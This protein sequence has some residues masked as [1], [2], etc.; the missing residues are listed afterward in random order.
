MLVLG[1][2]GSPRKKGNSS[3]LLS[4]FMQTAE[5]MGARTHTV[6]VTEKNIIPCKELIVCEK[7]GFC[8][9]D[10]DMKHE[11]YS[12]LRQAELIVPSTPIFFYNATAQL[13]ALIDRSQVLW[14][15]KYKFRLKDPLSGQ[16]KGFFLSVAA[17]KGKQLFDGLDLTMRYFFDALDAN[18]IGSLTYS[19]IEKKGDMQKHPTVQLD[20]EKAAEEILRPLLDR[21]KILFICRTNTCLSQMAGAFARNMAGDVLDVTTAGIEPGRKIDPNMAKVM[22]EIG[23]DMK[24]LHPAPLSQVDSER[25]FEK[26]FALEQHLKLPPFEGSRIVKW[27]FVDPSGQSIEFMRDI[28]DRIKETVKE[29]FVGF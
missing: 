4:L 13:K 5:K 9:I 15:R 1:L 16:R 10:D 29:A 2:Q 23:I 19:K 26:V 24:F 17:T 11:V 18:Y 27:N 22:K 20:V 14:S 6:E 3:Y 7:K 21:K 25:S 8:P 12:L 28:R